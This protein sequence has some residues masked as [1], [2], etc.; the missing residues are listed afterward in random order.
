M[1]FSIKTLQTQILCLI[2]VLCIELCMQNQS[3]YNASSYKIMS[4]L[5]GCIIYMWLQQ[6]E[7]KLAKQ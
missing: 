5:L 2:K 4:V 6:T 3:S 1:T 7:N